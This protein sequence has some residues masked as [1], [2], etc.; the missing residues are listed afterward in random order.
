MRTLVAVASLVMLSA[1]AARAE[2]DLETLADVPHW[3]CSEL[4]Q[5]WDNRASSK[6]IILV[7][8]W[9]RGFRDGIS[10]PLG[11]NSRRM[12]AVGATDPALLLSAVVV[13]CGRFP[14][15]SVG[16]SATKV[17]ESILQGKARD[18]LKDAQ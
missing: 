18:L 2:E 14:G 15:S 9:L 4:K 13:Y 11:K 16:E 1:A 3:G 8:S 7:S 17:V 12:Q 6:R 5:A 10:S